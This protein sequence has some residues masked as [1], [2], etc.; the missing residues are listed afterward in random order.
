VA[1]AEIAGRQLLAY[2]ADFGL[3]PAGERNVSKRDDYPDEYEENP[4]S[5]A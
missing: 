5:G 1:V 3:T 4:L 2:A